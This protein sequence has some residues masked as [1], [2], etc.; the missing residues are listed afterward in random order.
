MAWCP[1]GDIQELSRAELRRRKLIDVARKLFVENGF[2][3][4]GMAQIARESGIAVA[5]IYRDYSSK[6]DIVAALVE[7]DC[8]QM[9]QYRALEDA[10]Q[11]SDRDLTRTWLREFMEPSS[12]AD[13][14]MFV[15]IVAESAR[16][17]RIAEIFRTVQDDLQ[18]HILDALMLIAPGQEFAGRRALMAETV[19]TLSLGLLHYQLMRPELDVET[20]ARSLQALVDRELDRLSAG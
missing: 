8:A 10:I 6:E 12:R 7:S 5:Q 15:E 16:N 17:A 4:T 2:H 11:A 20:L 18:S 9:M 1:A 19:M 13:S 14:Q 3:A